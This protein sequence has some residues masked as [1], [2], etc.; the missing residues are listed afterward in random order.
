MLNLG[1]CVLSA[2]QPVAISTRAVD[3]VLGTTTVIDMLG[4]LT[5][6]W[7]K[8]FSW[9]RSPDAFQEADYRKLESS[10][11][12][13]F[14]PAVETG[15]PDAF[16]GA[17]RWISGWNR[18]LNSE[19]CF[20][21]RVTALEDL[22]AAAKRGQIGVLIGFQN[23]THFRTKADVASFYEQGQ[24][25]SQLTYNTRNRLGGGCFE[26]RDAGLTEFGAEIVSEMNRLGMAVDLSHCGERTSREAIAASRKPVLVTHSNCRALV[27]AQPRCKS[28][29]VLKALAANGGVMGITVVRAFVGSGRTPT[30]DDLLDHF[31]HLVKVAGIEHA[32]IGSDVDV[33]ALDPRTGR[34]NPIYSVLGLDPVARVFQIAD[35]LLQRGY[36]AKNVELVLGG[37]FYRALGAIFTAPAASAASGAAQRSAKR[38]PFCPAP[39]RRGPGSSRPKG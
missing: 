32:G 35:G 38:D 2:T 26:R 5:L 31:D 7:P 4:L 11:V 39:Q 16:Q 29:D 21:A 27:P 9:Q 20:L 10:G 14:H 12:T 13:L 6:D 37:N 3:L 1:R 17:L 23:S 30:F 15:A 8:L 36:S 28:D 33:T 18:L 24:R 22:P 25:V 19:S 34:T